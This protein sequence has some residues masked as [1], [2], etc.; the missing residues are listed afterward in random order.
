MNTNAPIPNRPQKRLNSVSG[1][2]LQPIRPTLSPIIDLVVTLQ[3]VNSSPLSSQQNANS[4]D[5]GRGSR[6]ELVYDKQSP[7]STPGVIRK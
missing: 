2:I 4:I 5:D 3:S 1:P 7:N 6:I